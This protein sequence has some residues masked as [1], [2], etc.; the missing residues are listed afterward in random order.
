[1]KDIYILA[2]ETSG[3]M[4]S[5]ALFCNHQLVSSK[6]EN[7]AYSHSEKLTLLI[8]ASLIETGIKPSQLSALALS[9]GPGSYTGLR[10]GSSVAKGMCYALEIPLIAI[11]TMAMMAEA[12][13][14]SI[15]IKDNAVIIPM[16]DA[17]RMEV[18]CAVFSAALDVIEA[19]DA[20][21]INEDSFKNYL[22]SQP[23]YFCGDG[24]EKCKVVFGIFPNAIFTDIIYPAAKYCLAEAFSKYEKEEFEDIAYFEPYYLKNF[25]ATQSKGTVGKVGI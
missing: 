7:T 14:A 2:I 22:D 20:K 18:Y 10:I 8:E 17:R 12:V 19:T 1:M 24:A 25:V 16:T 4:C 15:D 5:V 11:D 23:V 9:M 13:K 3:P 6:E 21:I